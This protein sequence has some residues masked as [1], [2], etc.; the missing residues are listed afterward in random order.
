MGLQGPRRAEGKA[1]CLFLE[2]L[3]QFL[4]KRVCYKLLAMS[5]QT[6]WPETQ[7]PED[8]R[9]TRPSLQGLGATARPLFLPRRGLRTAL[10][11]ILPR[12]GPVQ[13]WP[14]LTG[15]HSPAGKRPVTADGPSLL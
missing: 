7:V 10:R 15:A 12:A 4:Q 8:C 2:E 13:P 1:T 14:L 6:G 3:P 11:G 5:H 9:D